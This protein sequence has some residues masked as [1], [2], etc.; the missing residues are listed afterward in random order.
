MRRGPLRAAPY[1]FLLRRNRH[2]QGT[3]GVRLWNVQARAPTGATIT[4]AAP[5]ATATKVRR[6]DTFSGGAR[7]PPVQSA[8]PHA[9]RA[10][11]SRLLT[12]IAALARHTPIAATTAR[13]HPSWRY[14]NTPRGTSAGIAREGRDAPRQSAEMATKEQ[15][16][17][18]YLGR[19]DPLR[20]HRSTKRCRRVSPPP[21]RLLRLQVCGLICWHAT[22]PQAGDLRVSCGSGGET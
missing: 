2:D 7:Q 22:N 8:S 3:P 20:P 5:P 15:L 4:T 1:R 17:G 14:P 6:K 10:A 11:P 13:Y 12:M 9:A 16:P 21:S 18:P 19:G